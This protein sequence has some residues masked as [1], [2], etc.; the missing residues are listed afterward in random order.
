MII[1]LVWWSITVI[2]DCEGG[3]A[4]SGVS[5]GIE[6]NESGVALL[7]LVPVLEI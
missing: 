4:F 3:D 7:D 6:S 5:P 2:D 1:N